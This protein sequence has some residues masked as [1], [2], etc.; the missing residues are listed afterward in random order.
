METAVALWGSWTGFLYIA[1]GFLASAC[2]VNFIFY[3]CVDERRRSADGR[4]SWFWFPWMQGEGRFLS[5]Y[6]VFWQACAQQ[7]GRE[8]G[9]ILLE[10]DLPHFSFEHWAHVWDSV[11]LH[12]WVSNAEAWWCVCLQ[13][14]CIAFTHVQLGWELSVWK[15]LLW[16]PWVSWVG[17]CCA[18]HY[19]WLKTVHMS[20]Q[21][22]GRCDGLRVG[23][24]CLSHLSLIA[25]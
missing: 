2:D 15:G 16:K 7:E 11:L 24:I 20:F 18:L 19:L 25:W 10:S 6:S 8:G 22:H 12:C 3:P 14:A 17:N 21:V 4:V 1:F 23:F 13:T 9:S 5:G